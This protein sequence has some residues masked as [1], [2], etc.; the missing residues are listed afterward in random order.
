M[1]EEREFQRAKDFSREIFAKSAAGTERQRSW[2]GKDDGGTMVSHSC[3][4]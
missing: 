4:S 3:D 2:G 1:I